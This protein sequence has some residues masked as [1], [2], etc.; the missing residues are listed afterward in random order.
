MQTL[1]PSP[2]RP[3]LNRRA[4]LQR[5]GDKVKRGQPIIGAGAGTGLSA[6]CE[7][8]GGADLI[9]IYN[10]GRFPHGRAWFARGADGLW[11]CQ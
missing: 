2:L 10:S 9:V 6:K 1:N 7:E 4:I 11:Q 3:E 8:A 5:L